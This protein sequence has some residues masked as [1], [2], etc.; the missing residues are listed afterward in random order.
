MVRGRRGETVA[1]NRASCLPDSLRATP[2]AAPRSALP[3][4]LLHTARLVRQTVE[5]PTATLAAVAFSVT[6]LSVASK[7][8]VRCS[9]RTAA[10]RRSQW[11]CAPLV[12]SRSTLPGI[13]ESSSAPMTEGTIDGSQTGCAARSAGLHG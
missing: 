7:I 5:T 2:D 12:R 11:P 1:T 3:A 9:L 13:V 10:R 8:C 6:A 4:G